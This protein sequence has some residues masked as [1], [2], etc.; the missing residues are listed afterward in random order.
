MAAPC[1]AVSISLR[2]GLAGMTRDEA[3]SLVKTHIKNKN[4]VKHTLAVEAVM[5][6]L[7]EHFGE[8]IETWG[9][10]G[11]LHDID[12]TETAEDPARHSKLGAEMLEGMGVESD[13]VDAVRAHNDYHGLP[14]TTRM[15]RAL[16]AADPLTGLIVASAL[17]HP[18]KK[19][20]SIDA[21]FVVNRFGEKSF[22]RGARRDTISACSEI[23]LELPEFIALGLTAMQENATELGL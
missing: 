3:L 4:L 14:R 16:F 2:K 21:D 9:L 1:A 7:A 6:K 23:G 5:R 20:A 13:I 22:A 15:A 8:D 17:I 12:Y 18:D 19:L 11:L 10:T